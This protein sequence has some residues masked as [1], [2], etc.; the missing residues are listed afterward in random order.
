MAL[1]IC[2]ECKNKVSDTAEK[3]PSCGAKV[4]KKSSMLTWAVV[5]LLGLIFMGAI[6]GKIRAEEP[7][8]KLQR[9]HPRKKPWL[10]FP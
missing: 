10:I 9:Y 5:I 3:C 1:I 2:K 6:G 8:L 4:P 7:P